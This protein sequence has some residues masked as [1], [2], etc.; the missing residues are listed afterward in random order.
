[1]T[2][3]TVPTRSHV[4][5]LIKALSIHN[6]IVGHVCTLGPTMSDSFMRYKPHV[7]VHNNSLGKFSTRTHVIKRSRSESES[8]SGKL[9]KSPFSGARPNA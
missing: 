9:E 1:M 2:L 4:A 5:F 8:G 7:H 6:T 3:V